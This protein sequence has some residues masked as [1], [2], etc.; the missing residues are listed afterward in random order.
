MLSLSASFDESKLLVTGDSLGQ[1]ASQTIHNISSLYGSVPKA[2]VAPLIGM[3]KTYI[4]DEA[5]RIGTYDFSIQ[6]G[7]D[8]CQYMMCKTGANLWIG[9][10]TL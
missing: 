2:V 7:D 5:R 4:V 1:V 6:Q 9:K 3:H 10:R 8:C